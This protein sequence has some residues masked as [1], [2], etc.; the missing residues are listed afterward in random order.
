[1]I[2]ASYETS[3]AFSIRLPAVPNPSYRR[4]LRS[5][6]GDALDHGQDRIVIDCA[7][8]AELDLI[9]LSALVDCAG[10]CVEKG[11]SFELVNLRR[12]LRARIQ[13]LLLAERLGIQE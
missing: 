12:E 10:A 8:W 5:R 13:S 6:V 7:A 4:T 2:A 3:T 1:M 11:V 9:V